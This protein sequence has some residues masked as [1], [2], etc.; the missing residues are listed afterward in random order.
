MKLLAASGRG[1]YMELP[2]YASQVAGNKTH[3]ILRQA[4]DPRLVWHACGM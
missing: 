3:K 4:Q 2:F 1:I